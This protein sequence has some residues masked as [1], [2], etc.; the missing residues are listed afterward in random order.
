[1]KESAEVIV[2]G[3]GLG[4]LSVA[5]LLAR[6]GVGVLVI[7][8]A[9]FIG[10]RAHVEEKD[11]FLLDY[12]IHLSRF[13]KKGKLAEV[14]TA[15]GGTPEFTPPG[16]P[17]V[18]KDGKFYKFPRGPVG[19]TKTD[20]LSPRSKW[21]VFKFFVRLAMKGPDRY[22]NQTLEDVI[23]RHAPAQDLIDMTKLFSSSAIA[24]P[25]IEIAS[26]KEVRKF[27]EGVVRSPL[28]PIGYLKGGWKTYLDLMRKRIEAKGEILTKTKVEKIIVSDGR[29]AGVETADGKLTAKAVVCGVP[30]QHVPDII[31]SQHLGPE[32]T[33]YARRVE[34]TSGVVVDFALSEPVSKIGGIIMT[35]E[36]ATMGCLISNVD[37]SVAPPG[38]Q[39]GTWFQF[40]PSSKIGD[41]EYVKRETEGLIELIGRI[42][43]GVWDACLWKRV[44]TVPMIDG[45]MLKVGQTWTERAPLVAPLVP[46]L[47]F[48][49]D[50]TCG[51]GAGGDIALDSALR[52]A[53]L[54]KSCLQSQA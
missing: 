36:P 41:R 32:L 10:G 54:V 45:A 16:E 18:F 52:A 40:I 7:E 31:D 48:V 30:F 1:M 29:A 22:E 50:T 24:C 27:F 51:I 15:A 35:P 43:P 49:G 47:F 33:E 2:V 11:G 34:P 6:A 21:K 19:F 17:L 26:A 38:M 23:N 42:L 13:Q 39:L 44:L 12:G 5:A 37:P 3:A 8:R 46:N 9:P 28:E 14:I 53:K 25:Y 4:G 20:L